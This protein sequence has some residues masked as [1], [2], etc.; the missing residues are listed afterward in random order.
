MGKQFNYNRQNEYIVN[1][2]D[3]TSILQNNRVLR[4]TY[5]LLALTL[6]LSAV[7]AGWSMMVNA[8][9]I[10]PV[11]TMIVYFALLFGIQTNRNSHV[12]II[13]TFLLTGFLGFTLGPILNYYVNTFSNGGELVMLSLGTTSI[14]FLVLSVIGLDSR[15]DF[16]KLSSFIGVGSMVVFGAI[17]VNFFLRIPALHLVLSIIIALISGSFIL[18][19]TN[20]IVNGGEENYIIATITIYVSILNIFMTILQFLGIFAGDRD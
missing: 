9:L 5:L 8:P 15:R 18:W 17:I 14:I 3:R 7:T 4:N 10:N 2:R 13:L 12:G 16:S 20:R 19:Q 11:L 1:Q 6:L